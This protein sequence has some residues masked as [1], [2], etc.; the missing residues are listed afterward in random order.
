MRKLQINIRILQRRMKFP[1]YMGSLQDDRNNFLNFHN[2]FSFFM[3]RAVENGYRKV[4]VTTCKGR[5]SRWPIVGSMTLHVTYSHIYEAY[6]VYNGK[7]EKCIS[8]YKGKPARN[9]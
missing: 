4:L 9:P 3:I 8:S 2:M 5:T 1:N 7:S 6:S